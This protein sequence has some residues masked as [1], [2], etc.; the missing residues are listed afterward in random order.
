METNLLNKTAQW[1]TDKGLWYD[2]NST[3]TQHQVVVNGKAITHTNIHN[4]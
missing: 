1:Y 3:K 4:E 2:A